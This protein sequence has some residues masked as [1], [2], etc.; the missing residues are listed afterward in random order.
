MNPEGKLLL[1]A[2]GFWLSVSERLHVWRSPNAKNTKSSDSGGPWK[3]AG[4]N[5]TVY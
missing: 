1:S 5:H 4:G 2:V 3:W